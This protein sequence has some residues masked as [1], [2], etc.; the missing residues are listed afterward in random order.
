MQ[1]SLRPAQ[2]ADASLILEWQ[3]HSETRRFARNPVIPSEA[4]HLNWYARKIASADCQFLIAEAQAVPVGFLRLDRRGD[5]WELSIVVAPEARRHRFATT[6]L[7]LVDSFQDNRH[8]FAVVLP[9]N[10]ASH[11]LFQSAGWRSD[12]DRLYRKP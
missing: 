3:R 6:M 10:D 8:L 5:E 4:E 11:R 9:G 1:L 2:L 7:A 12:G